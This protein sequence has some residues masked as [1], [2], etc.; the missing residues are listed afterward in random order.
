VR[1]LGVRFETHD[2]GSSAEVRLRL[3]SREI[4]GTSSGF[5]FAPNP[6]PRFVVAEAT[7][8]ALHGI[9]GETVYSIE[10]VLDSLSVSYPLVVAVLSGPSRDGRAS[11]RYI[12]G[13]TAP[14]LPQA[15]CKAVLDA[16]NR[17]LARRLSVLLAGDAGASRRLVSPPRGEAR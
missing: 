3:G 11:Q 4:A 5:M 6:A 2:G 15:V 16:V 17:P 13:A 14:D 7:L 10:D 1:L 8:Q 12:G 9:L